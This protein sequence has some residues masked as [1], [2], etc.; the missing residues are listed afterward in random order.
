LWL[1]SGGNPGFGWARWIAPAVNG[2]V[3]GGFLW[4]GLGEVAGLSFARLARGGWKLYFTNPEFQ[5]A[6]DQANGLPLDESP[7]QLT[8]PE[9]LGIAGIG[10]TILAL[11]GFFTALALGTRAPGTEFYPG[12][13]LAVT[14]T[15]LAAL[16]LGVSGRRGTLAWRILRSSRHAEVQKDHDRLVHLIEKE[17]GLKISPL[18]RQGQK[19]LAP[20][21]GWGIF[22]GF[23]AA[24]VALLVW[25]ATRN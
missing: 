2:L 15:A 4:F 16:S 14:I 5:R 11:A 6:F 13:L 1:Y 23:L 19:V 20:A 8:G 18:D 9:R 17:E 25:M 7:G 12:P 22:L 21:V 3:F 10:I 24:G